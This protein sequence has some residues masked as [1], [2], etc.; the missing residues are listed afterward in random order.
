M[1]TRKALA[2]HQ[3][4]DVLTMIALS[5]NLADGT[6]RKYSAAVGRFLDTGGNLGDALSLAAYA[7]QVSNSDRVHLKAVVKLYTDR[8]AT[9]V[10]AQA[11]PDNVNEAQAA[12]MRLEALQ[13]AIRVKTPQGHKAHT[14]LSQTQVKRLLATCGDDLIGRRD[15]LALG[16]LVAAGLRREEAAR[17]TFADVILQPI[18]G[19]MRTVLQVE[20]KGAKSRAV[21]ISDSLANAIDEWGKEVGH[22][23]R[24]LRSV[25]R[26]RELR[27]SI[28]TVA[29][30]HIAQ[31]HGAA[32]GKPGL[33]PHDL[34][35][36]YAQLGYEAGVPITQISRLLGHASVATTQ[37]YLNLDLDLETTASDFIPF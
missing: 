32:I 16:L 7:E 21:P 2:V 37:K 23:G 34:R 22:V 20:G 11:T 8:L 6:K 35:R 36:T 19:K 29:L 13:E 28:S 31:A 25:D 1:T 5:P 12:L 30:Y 26:R 14:W 24:I 27:D 10:K 3:T 18:K 15:R 17:L 9:V 33:A 4:P